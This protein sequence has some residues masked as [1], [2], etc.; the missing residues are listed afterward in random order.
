MWRVQRNE[1]FKEMNVGYQHRLSM[2]ARNFYADM[3][4]MK[5]TNKRKIMQ[6]YNNYNDYLHGKRKHYRCRAYEFNA[7][8]LMTIS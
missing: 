1:F 3:N 6:S 8:L 4:F 5:T 2:L 7:N